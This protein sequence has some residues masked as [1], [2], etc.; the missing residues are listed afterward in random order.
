MTQDALATPPSLVDGGHRLF[1]WLR[2]MRDEQPVRE[3]A[4]GVVHVYRY[5]DVLTVASDHTVFSSELGRLRPESSPLSEEILSVIDPPMHRKLRSLVSQAFTPRTVAGLEP[6]VVELAGQ[7][8][9]DVPGDEFDLVRDF[10]FQLPVVV[11]AELLGVPVE[12][13]SLFRSWSERMLSVQ[14]DDAVERQFGDESGDEYQQMVRTPL[15]EMHAYLQQHVEDRRKR[16]GEDLISRLVDAEVDGDRLTDRQITEFGGLLLMAGHISTSLLLSNTVLCIEENPRIG[17]EVRA[18][19]SRIPQVIEEVLRYR[20]PIMVMARVTT[21]ETEIGGVP[22]PAN[23][24]VMASVVSA[25]H[26]ERQFPD[27]E[28]FDPR[29]R[30]QQQIAFGHGIHYCLG[31]PLARME[32]RVAL[33]AVLDAFADLR[34]TPDAQIEYHPDGLFGARRM[35]V[36]VRRH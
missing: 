18:D 33:E 7:M 8:L 36:T 21:R 19:R 5:A 13:Q 6:R 25:N 2:T 22:V 15:R 17:S 23:R 31:G 9:R 30:L 24:M 10:A 27:P 1:D 35:P 28:R 26:D 12:D 4:Y 20:P 29:R 3:D 32:G 16:R 11:I 14:V 34:I